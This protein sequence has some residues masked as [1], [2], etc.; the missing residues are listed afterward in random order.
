MTKLADNNKQFLSPS[1]ACPLAGLKTLRLDNLNYELNY[2]L[3]V[4]Q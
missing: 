4:A 1:D 2:E 3:K